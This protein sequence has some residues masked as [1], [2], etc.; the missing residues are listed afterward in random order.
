MPLPLS[1]DISC[2]LCFPRIFTNIQYKQQNNATPHSVPLCDSCVWSQKAD[3]PMFRSCDVCSWPRRQSAVLLPLVVWQGPYTPPQPLQ[4]ARPPPLFIFIYL[5]IAAC[6]S[7][8]SIG[9]RLII[10]WQKYAC[11]QKLSRTKAGDMRKIGVA[12]QNNILAVV[13]KATHTFGPDAPRTHS[14]RA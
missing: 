10:V 4:N 9:K 12:I 14:S 5:D 13:A 3:T 2:T 1:R 8:C 11:S 7:A 6:V